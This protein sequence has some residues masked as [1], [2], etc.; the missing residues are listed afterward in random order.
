[1][2]HAIDHNEVSGEDGR[3][4]ELAEDWVLSQDFAL[5]ML[6]LWVSIPEW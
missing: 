1:M 3:W 2:I 4:V 5:A 6:K